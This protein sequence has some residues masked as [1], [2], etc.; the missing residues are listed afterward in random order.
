VNTVIYEEDENGETEP[1]RTSN[2]NPVVIEKISESP[3]KGNIE[4]SYSQPNN[5]AFYSK[6]ANRIK[7]T[8]KNNNK[9][10]E[11]V[12]EKLLQCSMIPASSG[13]FVQ[14]RLSEINNV[15]K[16]NM[17]PIRK[18][19]IIGSIT[20]DLIRRK[21]RTKLR[22]RHVKIESQLNSSSEIKMKNDKLSPNLKGVNKSL[23]SNNILTNASTTNL[24]NNNNSSEQENLPVINQTKISICEQAGII[25]GVKKI[26]NKSVLRKQPSNSSN[27][28]LKKNELS[29]TLL[30]N[31]YIGNDQETEE[32]KNHYKKLRVKFGEPIYLMPKWE[33]NNQAILTQKLAHKSCKFVCEI[34]PEL[35]IFESLLKNKF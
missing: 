28:T 13:I 18:K 6:M 8:H 7:Q 24:N 34:G 29:K 23:F 26:I 10:S 1:I 33:E 15:S 21:C 20:K 14:K 12:I 16:Q 31:L 22:T 4:R 30:S 5:I 35:E 27:L 9:E 17:P 32:I 3:E 2:K 19:T 11:A 25:K